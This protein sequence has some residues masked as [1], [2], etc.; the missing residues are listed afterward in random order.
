M[1]SCGSSSTTSLEFIGPR[2]T[3]REGEGQ[4]R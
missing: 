3:G 2:E 4:E 1:V